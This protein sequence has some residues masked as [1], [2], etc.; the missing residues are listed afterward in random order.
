MPF[1]PL[2]AFLLGLPTSPPWPKQRPVPLSIP[3]RYRERAVC[4]LFACPILT[5]T[6]HRPGR[7]DLHASS[8]ELGS[9]L[10]EAST[11]SSWLRCSLEVLGWA[12]S[13]AWLSNHKHSSKTPY[14][15]AAHAES[16]DQ[17]ACAV[18]IRSQSILSDLRL[19]WRDTDGPVYMCVC[20]LTH[21]YSLMWSPRLLRAHKTSTGRT[22]GNEDG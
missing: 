1:L 5:S 17:R 16:E 4:S 9:V 6:I 14:S 3:C 21:S 13:Q 20:L 8:S 18:R 2:P 11:L 15:A 12:S 22:R 19:L 10:S 7:V